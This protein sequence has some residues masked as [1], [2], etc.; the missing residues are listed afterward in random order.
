VRR[1]VVALLATAALMNPGAIP[2]H[3]ESYTAEH[4]AP[5]GVIGHDGVK[6]IGEASY[7]GN[8]YRYVVWIG[9]DAEEMA[10]GSDAERAWQENDCKR[11]LYDTNVPASMASW[12][13]RG[14]DG[15]Y[16]LRTNPNARILGVG[17]SEDDYCYTMPAF[18]D[19][20]PSTIKMTI[21]RV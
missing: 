15:Q 20:D 7:Q 17:E 12:I 2:A 16:C 13:K 21:Q 18:P 19:F 3:A 11:S 5:K 6:C 9:A 1:W 10:S 14:Y 8:S 4:G